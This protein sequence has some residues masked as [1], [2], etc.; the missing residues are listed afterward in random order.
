MTKDPRDELKTLPQI[1]II[2][3]ESN[4]EGASESQTDHAS[5]ACRKWLKCMYL[6]DLN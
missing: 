4:S 5:Y 3:I 1:M 2:Q 6:F